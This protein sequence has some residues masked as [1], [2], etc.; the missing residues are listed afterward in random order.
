MTDT[1]SCIGRVPRTSPYS[2]R[3]PDP[4]PSPVCGAMPHP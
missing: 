1:R 3:R 2:L 4:S